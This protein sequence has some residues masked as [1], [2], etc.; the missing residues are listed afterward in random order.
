MKTFAAIDVGS[1]E[2]E[3]K[4]FELS[5]KKKVRKI[6]SIRHGLDLGSQTHSTGK[7]SDDKVNE[8]CHVLLDFKKIMNSYGVDGYKA[9]GTSAIREMQNRLIVLDQIEARC[10]I[11]IDVPSN[12]EQRFLNLKAVAVRETEFDNIIENST[13]VVDIGGAGLQIS[14]FEKGTLVSTQ[15]LPIGI[16]RIRE[17]LRKFNST[18]SQYEEIVEGLASSIVDTFSKLYTKDRHIDN[19]I[20]VDEYINV[21]YRTTHGEEISNSCS[22]EQFYQVAEMIRTLSP[23]QVAK[24][25]Q[26]NED[27]IELL[28]ISVALLKCIT[29]ALNVQTLWIPGATLCDGIAYEYAE[30]NRLIT[31]THNFEEDILSSAKN[32]SKRYMGSKKR[33]ETLEKIA[34]TVFDTIKKVHGMG[35]REKLLLRI[36]SLLHDCGR[37]I[38]IM[39]PQQAGYEIIMATEIIGLSHKEREIVAEVVKNSYSEHLYYEE[40]RQEAELESEDCLTVAKL[41]AILRLAT[42]LDRTHKEKFKE[43]RARLDKDTLYLGVNG[44]FDVAFEKNLFENRAGFFREVYRIEPVIK[45]K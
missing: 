2:L 27:S 44:D 34:V 33:G 24:K 14:L 30:K 5:E 40:I 11:H 18:M 25:V 13:A 1:Y 29:K 16:L 26:I 12:S 17:R 9:Y 28:Y 15:N 32:I 39:N 8:L 38:S 23:G 37:Y 21:A 41:A 10:G 43:L 7:L 36:A 3:L 20:L 4:I 22:T 35:K 19:I 42:G 45:Q 31:Y 6:D